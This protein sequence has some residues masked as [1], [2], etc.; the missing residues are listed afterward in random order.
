M[1][2]ALKP[3]CSPWAAAALAAMIMWTAQPLFAAQE[4]G[5]QYFYALQDR[6]IKDGFDPEI[7]KISMPTKTS[8]SNP[9]GFPSTFCITKPP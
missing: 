3:I 8:F 2:K 7:I 4:G 9:K 6:L 1:K 5:K